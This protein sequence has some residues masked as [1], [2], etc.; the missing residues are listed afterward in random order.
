MGRTIIQLRGAVMFIIII[1]RTFSRG[2]RNRNVLCISKLVCVNSYVRLEVFNGAHAN[3]NYYMVYSA[4]RMDA[5]VT[6]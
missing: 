4:L 1:I 3:I 6:L 5:A 2:R